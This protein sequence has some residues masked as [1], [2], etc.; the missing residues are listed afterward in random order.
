MFAGS[1][2]LQPMSAPARFHPE[3]AAPGHP[4][5]PALGAGIEWQPGLARLWEGGRITARG[6]HATT[7]PFEFWFWLQ[8]AE[9]FPQVSHWWFGPAWTGP[10]W[11]RPGPRQAGQDVITGT[12][13]FGD[14]AARAQIWQVQ[15]GDPAHLI[16][17]LPSLAATCGIC[18]FNWRWARL[19]GRPP[20]H[21]RPGLRT[22]PPA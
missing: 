18:R 1:A 15:P 19:S 4:F 13:Q 12:L 5:D 16:V 11:L 3:R 8:F 10:V 21:G 22:R 2:I 7:S 17:P 9:V 20:P 14:R 6:T